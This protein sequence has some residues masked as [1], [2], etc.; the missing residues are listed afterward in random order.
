M[1][2]KQ[3]IKTIK[4]DSDGHIIDT[5]QSMND[6]ARHNRIPVTSLYKAIKNNYPI[7]GYIYKYEHLS[8]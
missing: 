1:G 6:C 7:K 8:T 2:L 3:S 4:L 5:Y